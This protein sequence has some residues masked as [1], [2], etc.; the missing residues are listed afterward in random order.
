[1]ITRALLFALSVAFFPPLQVEAQAPAPAKASS[2]SKESIE[3]KARSIARLKKEG[4]PLI[5]HLPIIE[6]SKEAKVRTKEEIVQR[7][8]A[9]C[10]A[11]VKGEGTDQETIDFLVKKYGASKF[12][13]PDEAAFMKNPMPPQ[14]DRINAT[15]RY[16]CLW[17]LLWSLGYVD[18]LDRPEAICDV[19]NA[20]RV[21]ADRDTAT[22][23]KEAKL[24]PESEIL[25]EAD[26]IYRYHWAVT[27][28]RVKGRPAPAKLEKGVVK[29]RHY[30]LNWLIGYGGA[31]W[32]EVTTDT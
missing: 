17:V 6:D 4:V 22:L 9:I 13:S 26:L 14:Q 15:W 7:A 8:I 28:A 20:V 1:M 32:D 11:A 5:D 23:I 3:R 27:E 31:G 29:E 19:K 21:I 25:D 30:V 2:S 12:F 16:E 10:I 18:K 24:R